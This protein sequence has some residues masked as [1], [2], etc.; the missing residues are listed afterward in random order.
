MAQNQ[1]LD[2]NAL[3]DFLAVADDSG[4]DRA[5][6]VHGSSLDKREVEALRALS[7]K[8]IKELRSINDKITNASGFKSS[9]LAAWACGVVC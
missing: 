3:N 6:E 2:I 5:I 4:I 8:E 9:D 7:V 1:T